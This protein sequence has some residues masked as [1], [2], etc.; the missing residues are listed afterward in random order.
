MAYIRRYIEKLYN[1]S[2]HKSILFLSKFFPDLSVNV[3]VIALDM[4]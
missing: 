1:I 2:E 3:K 4:K